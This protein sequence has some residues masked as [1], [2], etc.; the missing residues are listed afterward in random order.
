MLVHT[1]VVNKP[2]VGDV[3]REKCHFG[4]GLEAARSKPY[5]AGL[6]GAGLGHVL[7]SPGSAGL[8]ATGRPRRIKNH[9]SGIVVENNLLVYFN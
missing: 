7:L 5:A 4:W 3:S 1:K 9:C 2:P 8:S 6:S